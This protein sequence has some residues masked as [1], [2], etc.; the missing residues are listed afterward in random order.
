[1][2]IIEKLGISKGHYISAP[3]LPEGTCY[4]GTHHA[5]FIE[6]KEMEHLKTAAPEMLE[7]LIDIL[8][9][10]VMIDYSVHTEEFNAIELLSWCES[11]YIKDRYQWVFSIISIIQKATNKSWEEIKEIIS[12]V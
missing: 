9:Q 11:D 3:K 7:A 8:I 10:R 5:M 2:N 1:M 6:S 12:H 4:T